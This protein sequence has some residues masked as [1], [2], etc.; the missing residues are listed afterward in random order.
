MANETI[1]LEKALKA[2][3]AKLDT[4]EALAKDTTDQMQMILAHNLEA[5]DNRLRSWITAAKHT[6]LEAGVHT[7]ADMKK[8]HPDVRLPWNGKGGTH[9]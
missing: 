8:R 5:F 3:R 4:L 2:H 1:Y 9:Q 7:F 6:P